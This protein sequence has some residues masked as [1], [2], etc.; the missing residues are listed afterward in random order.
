MIT[1]S[2][3]IQICK[4]ATGS[5]ALIPG[6]LYMPVDLC[7]ESVE[8]KALKENEIFVLFWEENLRSQRAPNFCIF[9]DE[10]SKPIEVKGLI[11]DCWSHQFQS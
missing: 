3:G 8:E 5:L 2:W 7:L 9:I 1:L 6:E 10:E 11:Q 4:Y